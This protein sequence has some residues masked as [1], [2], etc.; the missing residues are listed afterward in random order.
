[1]KRDSRRSFP[2]AIL[3]G[4]V[5]AALLDLCD[6]IVFYG[7]KGVAPIKIPQSIASGLLGRA[8]YSGGLHAVILGL[9]LHIFIALSWTAIFV[10]A[11]RGIRVLSQYPILSGVIYGFL[12]YAFMYSLVLPHSNL[13]PRAHPTVAV[14]LNNVAAMVFL[15]GVPIALANV[16]LAP[17]LFEEH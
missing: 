8:A 11:A 5:I 16:Y 9:A 12:V 1:M 7:L 2:K 15:V 10:F 4:A 6:A 17:Q 13:Y 3:V 14:L